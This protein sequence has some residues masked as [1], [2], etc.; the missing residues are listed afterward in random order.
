MGATDHDDPPTIRLSMIPT[1]IIVS[2]DFRCPLR[3]PEPRVIV[4]L[5]LPFLLGPIQSGNLRNSQIVLVSSVNLAAP[6]R[7]PSLALASRWNFISRSVN[8]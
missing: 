5:Y 8:S 2:L 4:S 1:F 7:H 3:L 6:S